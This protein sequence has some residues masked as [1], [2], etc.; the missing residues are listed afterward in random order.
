MNFKTIKVWEKLIRP[1]LKIFEYLF[2]I[3]E[4]IFLPAIVLILIL[5]NIFSFLFQ[6][7]QFFT[8]IFFKL[9]LWV[10]KIFFSLGIFH[11]LLLMIFS[12]I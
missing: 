8:M 4:L 9:L 12:L 5:T 1:I 3:H 6:V 2:L 10:K 7:S 11:L